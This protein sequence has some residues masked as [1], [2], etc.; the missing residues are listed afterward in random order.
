MRGRVLLEARGQGIDWDVDARHGV[1]RMA[2]A[3]AEVGG[4]GGGGGGG[5]GVGGRGGR[6]LCV[7]AA[8]HLR[9]DWAPQPMDEWCAAAER[10]DT[11]REQQ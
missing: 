3:R 4:G 11:T 1:A 9:L 2:R 6:G 7:S 10:G 5:E 8:R